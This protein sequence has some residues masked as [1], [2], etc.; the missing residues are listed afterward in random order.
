MIIQ[1][2][3]LFPS[4]RPTGQIAINEIS[5]LYGETLNSRL[6]PDYSTLVKNGYVYVASAVAA[7][8]SA[9]VGGAA[10]TPLIGLSNPVSSGK[11]AH[12]LDII[13][14]VR[15]LGS[16]TANVDFNHWGVNQGS[17]AI[18]GVATPSRNMYSMQTTGS[19]M[20]AYSNV[21]NTA[22]LATNLLRSSIS[23]GVVPAVATAV[24]ALL[25]DELKGEIV[26]APGNYYAFGAAAAL[27]AAS[28]DVT[29]IWAEMPI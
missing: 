28:I 12:L 22:A 26:V 7:N 15:N 9:F 20:S 18:T 17:V 25:R 4:T 10:G 5:G 11:D 21:V 24:V 19:A 27:T 2:T 13:V 1:K 29:L 16:A 23:L 14:G 6:L 3:N 8:P